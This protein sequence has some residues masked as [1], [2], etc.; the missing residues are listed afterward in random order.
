MN[1]PKFWGVGSTLVVVALLI[2]AGRSLRAA[3]PRPGPSGYHIAKTIPVTGEG[4]WDYLIVD[5]DA[6]RLYFSHSTR[7][8]VFDADNYTQVGEIPD[9]QGVHGIALAPDL[10]RGFTSNGRANTVTIFD[11][12]TLKSIGTAKTDANPDAIIY[13]AAT[14][15]VFSFNGRGKN[16]TAINAA[17]GSVVGAIPLGG[18][19][20]FAV[21]DDKG[22]VYVNDEDTSELHHL[23]SQN[24]KE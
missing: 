19:P 7:V 11:L 21:T 17:D 9:T 20:E 16:A 4:G 24:L 3:S 18:R 14:K 1:F 2:F 8:L 23:D 10:G 5:A 12:Q 22:S 15:R 6:R 13:D